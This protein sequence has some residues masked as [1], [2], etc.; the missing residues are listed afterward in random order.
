MHERTIEYK[1]LISAQK[2]VTKIQENIVK[3]TMKL[4]RIKSIIFHDIQFIIIIL[5]ISILLQRN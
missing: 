4:Y 1:K 3:S 5:Y 2:T